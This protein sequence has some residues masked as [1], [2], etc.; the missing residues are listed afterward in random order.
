[1]SNYFDEEQKRIEE[2]KKSL[3]GKSILELCNEMSEYTAFQNAKDW[4]PFLG[5]VWE[6]IVEK[7]EENNE[8]TK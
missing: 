5:A 7:L 6:M 1:M 3:Q 2:H 8:P 4:N